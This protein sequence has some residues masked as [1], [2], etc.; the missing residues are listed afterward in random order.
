MGPG[1]WLIPLSPVSPDLLGF[2]V[3][4]SAL[5]QGPR[6]DRLFGLVGG[7][8][9]WPLADAHAAAAR[10]GGPVPPTGPDLP[11]GVGTR[12]NASKS[13]NRRA[14][15]SLTKPGVSVA[16]LR[17]PPGRTNARVSGSTLAVSRTSR[18]RPIWTT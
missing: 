2:R 9:N 12:R 7:G 18:A 14:R 16:A 6:S 8:Q 13:R 4:W 3:R 1:E 10:P 15:A 17:Q 11:R 5:H